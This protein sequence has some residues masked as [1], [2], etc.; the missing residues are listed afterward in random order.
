M[1]LTA[2]DLAQ[3]HQLYGTYCH[4]VDEGDGKAFSACF[5]TDGVLDAGG[6]PVKGAEALAGFADSIPSAVPGIRHLVGNIVVS[7]QGDEA[8]GR[9]YLTAYSSAGGAT[10]VLTTGR[11]RDR[12]RRQD[13]RWL[14]SER[15]FAVD[16]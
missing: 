7:G 8:E 6:P 11:Y 13:G 12:L 9:A 16:A 4:S 5:T 15:V 1:P 10:Q 3:I 14:F 2:D